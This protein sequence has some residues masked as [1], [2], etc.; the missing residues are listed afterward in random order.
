[1]I[2][3]PCIL[4]VSHAKNDDGG[5]IESIQSFACDVCTYSVMLCEKN[6][7]E[8]YTSINYQMLQ[9]CQNLGRYASNCKEISRKYL[10]KIYSAVHN[11]SINNGQI[12]LLDDLCSDD[13]EF[14]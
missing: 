2:L 14:N 11:P 5:S 1:M 4:K 13:Y 8:S 7:N 6:Y 10:L 9:Y 3:F 12:C